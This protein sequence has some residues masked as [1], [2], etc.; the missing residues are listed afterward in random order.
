MGGEGSGYEKPALDR[1]GRRAVYALL[2]AVRLVELWRSQRLQAT[3][4]LSVVVAI[5][6][7]VHEIGHQTAHRTWALGQIIAAVAA[8]LPGLQRSPA[9]APTTLLLWNT[10]AHA[11][12][13]GGSGRCHRPITLVLGGAR[14]GK[15]RPRWPRCRFVA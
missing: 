5:S 12:M 8:T 2:L 6:A 15:G 9:G 10:I 7:I 13:V 14:T 3:T 4:S 1:T 11:G